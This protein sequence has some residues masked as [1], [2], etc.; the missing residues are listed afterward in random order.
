MSKILQPATCAA[1]AARTLPVKGRLPSPHDNVRFEIDLAWMDRSALSLILEY[2]GRREDLIRCGAISSELLEYR[3]KN[4]YDK[5]TEADGKRLQIRN[6]S[7]PCV[8]ALRYKSLNL[9]SMPGFEPWMLTAARAKYQAW[10]AEKQAL[11]SPEE[12]R[13]RM[14]DRLRS[15]VRFVVKSVSVD[16]CLGDPELP[17][18][19]LPLPADV[20][21]FAQRAKAATAELEAII[22]EMRI[23]DTHAER[24]LLRLVVD[25]THAC[26]TGRVPDEAGP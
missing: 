23:V 14:I 7:K 2:K 5:P 12:W 1:A 20:E 17:P 22:N 24:R 19:M 10:L 16:N 11:L 6:R 26:S 18:G 21:G 9:E 15:S 13:E 8:T 25:N 3:A 4:C